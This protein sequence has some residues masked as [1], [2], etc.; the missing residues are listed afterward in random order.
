MTLSVRAVYQNGQLRLLGS[1][2]LDEGQA[3]IIDI[4]TADEPPNAAGRRN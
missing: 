4:R 1:V 3:V 2:E